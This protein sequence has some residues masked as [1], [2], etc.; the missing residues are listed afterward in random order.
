MRFETSQQSHIHNAQL[1]PLLLFVAEQNLSNIII[2]VVVVAIILV[3]FICSYIHPYSLSD[4]CNIDI[5]LYD[6]PFINFQVSLLNLWGW[7]IM[8][9]RFIQMLKIVWTVI[10][11]FYKLLNNQ[12]VSMCKR[13][14]HISLVKNKITQ[15]N[16]VQFYIFI[17]IKVFKVFFSPSWGCPLQSISKYWEKSCLYIK[18]KR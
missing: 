10:T 13:A 14:K 7:L 18:Q 5:F 4:Y 3:W 15:L 1:H 11:K 8:D 6:F 9:L 16:I 12:R 17:Y 2:V